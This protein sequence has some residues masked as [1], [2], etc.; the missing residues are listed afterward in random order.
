MDRYRRELES[1]TRSSPLENAEFTNVFS[2]E[3][4]RRSRRASRTWANHRE[5][6]KRVYCELLTL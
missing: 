1:C 3:A 4:P 6:T 2:R 5:G